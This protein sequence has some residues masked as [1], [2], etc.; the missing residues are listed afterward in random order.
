MLYPGTLACW[1]QDDALQG[2]ASRD[3]A[4]ECDHQLACQG[5]DHRLARAE[6]AIG[7]AGAVPQWQCALLLKQQ[8]APGELDHA[9]AN[10]RV[11]GS[12]EPLFPPLGAALVRRASQTGV[13]RHRFSVTHWP[14][15]HLMDEHIGRFNADADNPRQL[16]NHGVWP[17]LRLLLQSFLTSVLDLSDLAD[18]KAQPRHI[19]LQLGQGIW[20]Q[21]HALRDVHGCQTFGRLAQSGFE[22]ANAQP[23]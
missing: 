7:S 11:A 20:R 9:A 13:A 5:D 12:G 17:G 4:P 18:D 23:G 3:K 15:E 10:P 2:L 16:P 14:R 19:A 8:E 22:V 6:P 1:T 21:R